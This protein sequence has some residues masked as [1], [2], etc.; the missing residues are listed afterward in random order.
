MQYIVHNF[1]KN[2]SFFLIF[3]LNAQKKGREGKKRENTH[4]KNLEFVDFFVILVNQFGQPIQKDRRD[5]STEIDK[6][7]TK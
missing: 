3:T 5:N 7:C 1:F 2:L 6:R 4:E